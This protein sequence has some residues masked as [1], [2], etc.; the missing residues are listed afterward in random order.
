[1]RS[2]SPLPSFCAPMASRWNSRA[3]ITACSR[4]RGQSAYLSR[5]LP[6]ERAAGRLFD[7]GDEAS[8]E[9]VDLGVGQGGFLRLQQDRDREGFLA[10][11]QAL[12]LVDVEQADLA[13]QLAVDTARRTQ[14]GFGRQVAVDDKGEI[15]L[16]RLK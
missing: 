7:L 2:T 8:R 12:A 16:D 4:L 5:P 13:D 14:Q 1:M 11:G 6:P 9:G 3:T 10:V 15:A